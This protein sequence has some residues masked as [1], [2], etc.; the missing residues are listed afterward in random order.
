MSSHDTIGESVCRKY[1]NVEPFKREGNIPKYNR[2]IQVLL[3][4]DQYRDFGIHAVKN[5]LSTDTHF[6]LIS[7]ITRFDPWDGISDNP[8]KK[9]PSPEM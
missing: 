9:P 5:I 7:E 2:K 8:Y 4:E 3:T 1:Y 6:D